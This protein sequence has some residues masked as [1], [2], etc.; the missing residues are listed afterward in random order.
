[1]EHLS[2]ALAILVALDHEPRQNQQTGRH[3][4]PGGKAARWWLEHFPRAQRWA[5][6][7]GKYPGEYYQDHGGDIRAWV[8]AGLPPVFHVEAKTPAPKPEPVPVTT[9][10]QPATEPARF[11]TFK[12]HSGR[13]FHVAETSRDAKAVA[14]T[15]PEDAVFTTAEIQAIKA[16]GLTPEEAEPIL[17]AR[18]IF[19]RAGALNIRSIAG[20]GR[21]KIVK[22]DPSRQRTARRG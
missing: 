3:E 7:A 4:N 21:G 18:Q 10:P 20:D 8:L 5:T 14:A 11:W 17:L 9:L 1:M 2:R 15:H 19:G 16:E 13:T 22:F 6:P 12:S